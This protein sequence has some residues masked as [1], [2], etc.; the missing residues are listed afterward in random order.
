MRYISD[1]KEI[2]EAE[3]FMTLAAEEAQKS[4]CKK[5]KRGVV[6]VNNGMIIGRGYNEPLLPD[7][8][9]VRE[10]IHDNT[11]YDLCSALHAEQMAIA[12]A[13]N[14]LYRI[15]GARLYQIKTKNGEKVHSRNPSC[16]LCS[17]LIYGV[18]I[19]EVVLWHKEGY[20]VYD[21]QEFN[22]LS[23]EYFLKSKK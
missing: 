19:S 10:N 21:S 9:C 22:R 8:C 16:T 3:N 5:S 17:R 14:G 7:L 12:E 20:A 23:Y 18:K 13:A 4:R 15:Q 11:R 2:K 6:L 1:E